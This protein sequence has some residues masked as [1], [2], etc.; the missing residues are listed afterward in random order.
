MNAAHALPDG[1]ASAHEVRVRTRTEADAVAVEIADTGRGISP[2]HLNRIF[3][4]F[5][6][7]KPVGQGTGLGL[8][9][10]QQIV[11]AL[12]GSISVATAEGKGTTFTVRLP[13]PP[14]ARP[15]AKRASDA[16]ARARSPARAR[17]ALVDDEPLLGHAMRRLLG[18]HEVVVFGA[19]RQALSRIEGGDRFDVILCDL[20]MPE[21]TGMELFEALRAAV[22]EQAERMLF[23]TGGAFTPSAREFLEAR[24]GRVLDKPIELDVLRQRIDEALARPLR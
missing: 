8:P 9:I 14:V 21:M 7:T 23:M 11:H 17:V 6:S 18:N 15:G 3:D 10:S 1:Q 12:G 4:P 19:A 13:L 5:F 24:P 20:L 16:P 22:P 2:E